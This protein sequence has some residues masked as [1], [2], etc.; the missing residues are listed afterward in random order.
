MA[1]QHAE[2]YQ[3]SSPNSQA[4]PPPHLAQ[5]SAPQFG[6]FSA[7]P[8]HSPQQG[9]GSDA[10]PSTQLRAGAGNN[11]LLCFLRGEMLKPETAPS[12]L[13]TAL[14]ERANVANL[15]ARTA[16][17]LPY[18]AGKGKGTRLFPGKHLTALREGAR[19]A[20]WTADQDYYTH[21]KPKP[22]TLTSSAL[23]RGVQERLRKGTSLL[24]QLAH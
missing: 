21:A 5:S 20:V 10:F 3:A 13:L 15:E 23:G 6:S 1:R 14:W 17:D 19:L 16:G 9:A 22:I 18:L 11:A 2:T 8:T 12:S 4:V 24:P 7:G